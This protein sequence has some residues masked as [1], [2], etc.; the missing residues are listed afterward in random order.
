MIK[1]ILITLISCLLGIILFEFLYKNLK[2][3]N[4]S[5]QYKELSKIYSLWTDKNKTGGRI[6][7]ENKIWTYDKNNEFNHR[8]FVKT[9]DDW[10]EE[11]NYKQKSNNF[12][13]NQERNLIQ[14][15]KSILLLGASTPE[16]W[17]AN[18]WFNEL[19]REFATDYQLVNGSL[20]GT[21]VFSW[22]I[23]HDHLIKQKIN[24][25]KVLIFIHGD[26]WVNVPKTYPQNHIKCLKN[27]N[28]CTNAS[29]L[30]YGMPNNADDDEIK[31]YLNKLDKIRNAP[32][33]EKF[34]N[35]TNTKEFL[36]YLREFL[37]ATY[38][39]YRFIRIKLNKRLNEKEL[40]KFI[41]EY[42]DNLI[43]HHLPQQKEYISSTF[44]NDSLSLIQ[45]VKKNGGNLF[46]SLE[47][48]E[49]LLNE[50]FFYYDGHP[51]LKG[52]KKIKNCAKKALSELLQ[53]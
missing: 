14:N 22:R 23:L 5:E 26:F 8:L 40:L 48:C 46:N 12:G 17:G 16:G 3:D 39:I 34:S 35:V 36:F 7:I 24:I 28:D 41:N 11:F 52:Y 4:V 18:P 47:K 33:D 31:K 44:T 15:K 53:N 6:N 42:D 29:F 13:L 50:D 2:L 19:Q 43:I 27:F 10:Y 20:H 25:E 37:P 1:K 45:F 9:G 38:Q 51:N 21:G 32:L 49:K 30:H